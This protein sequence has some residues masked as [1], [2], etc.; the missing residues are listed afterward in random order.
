MDT[1][2]S[3]YIL[4]FLLICSTNVDC[5]YLVFVFHSWTLSWHILM[6][7]RA[8]KHGPCDPIPPLELPH[9]LHAFHHISE[10]D[11]LNVVRLYYSLFCNLICIWFMVTRRYI[12]ELKEFHE[13]YLEFHMLYFMI[14]LEFSVA[15]ISDNFFKVWLDDIGFIS[16]N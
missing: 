11:E 13:R 4:I 1:L 14:W 2:C 15:M 10:A 16:Y 8:P 9:S 6:R 7:M 5:W 12:S 3:R